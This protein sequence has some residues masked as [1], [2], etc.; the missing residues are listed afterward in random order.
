MYNET[1]TY[2]SKY[3]PN[4]KMPSEYDIDFWEENRTCGDDVKV[5]IKF[6]SSG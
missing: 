2:Y 5:Y 1:I 3:A 4:K 6:A